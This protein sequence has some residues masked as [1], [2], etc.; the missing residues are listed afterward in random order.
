MSMEEAKR[1]AVELGLD[2]AEEAAPQQYAGE[3]R[4]LEIITEE[5]LFYKRQAG[6]SIIEIGKRLN[7]AKAQL[8]HGEWLPW[9]RERV[10]LSERSAQNFMRLARE[11]SKNAEIADLGA[12]KALALLA[13]PECERSAFAAEAHTVNGEKKTVSEMTNGELKQAI[14]ERDMARLAAEEAQAQART[15]RENAEKL[16]EEQRGRLDELQAAA[17]A[18]EAKLKKARDR[19]QNAR[20]ELEN[21]R[22]EKAEL[23]QQVKA[24]KSRPVEVAVKEPGQ[25]ELDRIRAE[26]EAAAGEKLKDAEQKLAKANSAAAAAEKEAAELRRRLAAADSGTQTFKLRFEAW[27]REYNAMLDALRAVAET[28]AEKAEKLKTAIRAAA[29]GMGARG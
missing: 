26:A 18:M 16:L 14:A 19:E 22:T 7:E 21:A 13:L 29:A 11:Y 24:L 27:Q 9:L 20:A 2:D 23:E 6:A 3:A 28:D 10:D 4:G 1:T 12:G 5:I 15:E 17:D 25:E 8:S